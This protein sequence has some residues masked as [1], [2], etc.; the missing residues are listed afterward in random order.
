M[1]IYKEVDEFVECNINARV[2]RKHVQ[3]DGFETL[4]LRITT[5]YI[6]SSCQ[7]TL[8]ISSV[9]IYKDQQKKGLFKAL[10]NHCEKLCIKHKLTL[11]IESVI[12][13]ELAAYLTRIGYDSNGV[14]ICAN[15]Y[16]THEQLGQRHQK[17]QRLE[18]KQ[19]PDGPAPG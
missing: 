5:R 1:N 7:R 14:E 4:Y 2:A 9:S 3:V 19:Q 18:S 17:A 12:S 15:Y 11:F 13:P 6:E 16:L 8:D 10:L